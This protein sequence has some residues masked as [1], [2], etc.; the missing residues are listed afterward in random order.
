MT[1]SLR[2]LGLA[3]VA[4]GLA[5][6]CLAAALGMAVALFSSP[7]PAHMAQSGWV[8]PS[9]CYSDQDCSEVPEPELRAGNTWRFHT[10]HVVPDADVKPAG[11]GRWHLCIDTKGKLLCAFG[12]KGGA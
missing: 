7:A 3:L 6:A 8:Y 4:W 9:Q 10:G 11:D 5:L 1:P 2:T 12:P